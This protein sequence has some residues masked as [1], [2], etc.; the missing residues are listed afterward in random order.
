M[1]THKAGGSAVRQSIL[2]S[3]LSEAVCWLFDMGELLHVGV[4]FQ[5][6]L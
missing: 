4:S 1:K 2:P 3:W 5:Y 6:R